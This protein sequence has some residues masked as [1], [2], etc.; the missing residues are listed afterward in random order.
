MLIV[1]QAGPYDSQ[2]LRHNVVKEEPFPVKFT[3]RSM[4]HKRLIGDEAA[5]MSGLRSMSDE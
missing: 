5:L 1:L 4:D 3:V 2:R